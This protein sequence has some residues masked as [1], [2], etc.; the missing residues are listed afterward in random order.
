M[1]NNRRYYDTKYKCK[2]L[3]ETVRFYASIFVCIRFCLSLG[4]YKCRSILVK[5][6]VKHMTLIVFR[7]DE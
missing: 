1:D 5:K 6:N 2:S 7:L 4:R 3:L